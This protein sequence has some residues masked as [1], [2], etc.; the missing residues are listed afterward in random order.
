M[1]T[2]HYLQASVTAPVAFHPL[3]QYNPYQLECLLRA[4]HSSLHPAVLATATC[5]LAEGGKQKR[6]WLLRV[7]TACQAES[8]TRLV[9]TGATEQPLLVIE[10]KW[11]ARPS[12]SPLCM[13]LS[14]CSCI[15]H[16]IL[17]LFLW[18]ASSC[19][20]YPGF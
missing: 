15:I 18:R 13:H 10:N 2:G 19:Q 17:N 3:S 12:S 7:T 5:M 6:A 11:G 9:L 16:S 8:G 1:P 14:V 20:F 4:G